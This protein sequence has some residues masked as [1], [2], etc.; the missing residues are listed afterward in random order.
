MKKILPLAAFAILASYAAQAQSASQPKF[1]SYND[2]LAFEITLS[3]RGSNAPKK[4]TLLFV[5][6]ANKAE[7]CK[8]PTSQDQL[9]R[10]NFRAYWDGECKNGFAFGLGRDIEISDTHHI[11][12]I[13]I[14]D[15]TGDNWSQPRVNYDYVNNVVSYNVGGSTFPAQTSLSERMVDSISGFNAYQTLS[16]VDKF[17]K[18]YVV[19]SSAFQPQRVF[20]ITDGAVGFKFTDNSAAP[21]TNQ[22]APVFAA[23]IVDPKSNYKAVGVAV[24]RFANGAT[25]DFEI[26]DGKKERV[27]VPAAYGDHLSSQYQEVLNVTSQASANLERAQQIERE[28]LYKAC[29]GK[30]SIRGL[31]NSDYTKICTWRDQFKEPYA[32]ASANYQR[33][34]ESL[35]QQATT[36]EQQRQIQ[37]QIAQQQEML[38]QQRNQQAWNEANRAS[39][40][41]LDQANQAAQQLQQQAQRGANSW[42]APQVQPIAPPGG[43]RIVCNTIGS[44]TTCR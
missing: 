36:A 37:Q 5:Q 26:S 41:L 19:Q 8:V 40:Q 24:V 31:D 10:P 32:I 29:N 30:S 28:Y 34:L 11:E 22:N 21:V 14:H 20:I 9:D 42:Q 18:A 38:Q 2:A 7:A 35:R 43:N 4:P 3:A 17:G 27:S 15:G 16:V 13:T 6:P 25:Y 33:Q 1:I 39:Q 23:E 12:E 44:I